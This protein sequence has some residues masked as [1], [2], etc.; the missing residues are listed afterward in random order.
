MVDFEIFCFGEIMVMFVVEQFGELDWVEQ[1]GKCI[2]GVD[3]N[4]V[5]GFVC[6]GFMVVWLSWVGDDL[7]GCFVFDS[8]ICEGFDCCFVEVD[9]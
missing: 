4:V 2:V 6:F 9:V 3:S 5:I 1:F 8:L 7:F